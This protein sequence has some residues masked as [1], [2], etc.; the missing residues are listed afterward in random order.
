[1]I[2][3]HKKRGVFFKISPQYARLSQ[4]GVLHSLAFEVYSAENP[5]DVTRLLGVFEFR[6]NGRDRDSKRRFK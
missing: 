4:T 5:E 2:S 1:M 6:S 3:S